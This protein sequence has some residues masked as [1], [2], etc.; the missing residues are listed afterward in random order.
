M[1]DIIQKKFS[2]ASGE[3]AKE[4]GHFR[5]KFND[6]FMNL[7]MCTCHTTKLSYSYIIAQEK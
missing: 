5:K 1:T 4:Y 7:N 3:N 6:F 2:Q